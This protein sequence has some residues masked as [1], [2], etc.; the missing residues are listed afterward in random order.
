MQK[1]SADD[2]IIVAG[3]PNNVIYL[4]AEG[5]VD[6]ISNDRHFPLKKGDIVGI[7]DITLPNHICSYVATSSCALVPYGF[8]N[9]NELLHIFES[10][11]DLRRLLVMSLTKNVCQLISNHQIAFGK[12]VE[13]Y[14]YISYSIKQYQRACTK[15]SYLYKSLPFMENFSDETPENTMPFFLEDYYSSMKT[16]LSQSGYQVSS[17]FLFG[18]LEK[19]MEDIQKIFFAFEKIKETMETLTNHVINEEQLDLFELYCNLYFRMISNDLDSPIV[20]DLLDEMIDYMQS[21][22]YLDASLVNERINAFTKKEAALFANKATGTEDS[23]VSASDSKIKESLMGSLDVILDYCETVPIAATEFK[24]VVNEFKHVEDKNSTDKETDTIRRKLAKLFYTLYIETI[25]MTFKKKSVPTIVKMFLNFGYIDPDLCGYRHAITLYKIAETYHGDKDRG[26]YTIF[27]WLQEIYLGNKQPSRN[28]FELDYAAYVRNLKRERRIDRVAEVEMM[29]D[30][31]A[32]VLYELQNM[33]PSVNKITF[34]R[35]YTFCPVLIEENILRP[36]DELLVTTDKIWKTLDDLTQIDYSAFYHDLMYEEPSLNFKESIKTD[37][38]PDVILMPNIGIKGIMWQEIEGMS[39]STPCRMMI[40]ALH[41]ENLSKTF[42]R[43]MGEFRWEMCKRSQGAH[44]NDVSYKSLTSEYF[45]Y[46]Q[47]HHKNRDLSYEA[48]E[49]IKTGLKRCKNNYRE[50]FLTDYMTY[51]MYEST[52]SCRLNKVARMIIFRYCPFSQNIR[53]S[54]QTNSIFSECLDKHRLR[55]AQEEH[56]LKQI[57][58]RYHNAGKI[59][60]ECIEEQLGFIK[61]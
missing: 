49:K 6:A 15:L 20:T 25:Q 29:N 53:E 51:M 19:S 23:N 54:L 58:S 40:S 30:A 21:F 11:A 33:F 8:E 22:A 48:K 12:C 59:V 55:S 7:F 17:S 32:K 57:I 2:E 42:I 16:L 45:D 1:Y 27:E 52:G 3:S 26:V 31:S 56:H 37:I 24:N 50:M 5:T 10:N 39:R 44:W 38:R 13:F 18:F 47:F 61:K 43:M 46:I 60:P 14:R 35:I 28:E 9:R 41:M 34:G 4:I 36:F